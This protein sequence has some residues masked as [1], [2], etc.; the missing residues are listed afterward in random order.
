[1]IDPKMVELMP[2]NGIPH[3]LNSVIIDPNMAHGSQMGCK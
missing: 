2:Y 3:L 1:M